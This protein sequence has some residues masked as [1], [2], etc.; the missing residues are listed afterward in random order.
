MGTKNV[1]CS[2]T[3]HREAKLPWCSNENDPRCLALKERIADAVEAVHSSGVKHF[4]CGMATGC[5]M[6]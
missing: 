3:G 6:Y 1:A 5:D 2:F 4:I